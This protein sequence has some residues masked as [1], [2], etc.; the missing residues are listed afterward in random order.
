[1]GRRTKP[2]TS[3]TLD[4]PASCGGQNR[5]LDGRQRVHQV[6]MDSRTI[7]KESD[8]PNVGDNPGRGIEDAYIKKGGVRPPVPVDSGEVMVSPWVRSPLGCGSSLE[9]VVVVAEVAMDPGVGIPHRLGDWVYGS[10]MALDSP[11]T[12]CCARPSCFETDAL[13]VTRARACTVR[14]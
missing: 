12:A 1:M 8:V 11:G 6:P 7:S 9:V 10:G 14:P 3:V 2:C 5:G 13:V 4:V